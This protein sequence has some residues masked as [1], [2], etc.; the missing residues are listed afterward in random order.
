MIGCAFWKELKKTTKLKKSKTC[1][2]IGLYWHFGFTL[3]CIVLL[4]VLFTGTL[5]YKNITVVCVFIYINPYN[6]SF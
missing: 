1:I 2:L 3:Y 6:A 5:F 4:T